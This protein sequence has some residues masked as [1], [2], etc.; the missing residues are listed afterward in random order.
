[1][2]TGYTCAVIVTGWTTTDC[3]LVGMIAADDE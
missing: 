2:R 3:Q 1:M